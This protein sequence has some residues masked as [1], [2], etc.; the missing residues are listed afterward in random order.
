MTHI[1]EKRNKQKLPE[2]DQT[3]EFPSPPPHAHSMHVFPGQGSNLHHS[4][5]PSHS[6]DYTES[7]NHQATRELP[8][9]G[10]SKTKALN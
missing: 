9:N 2:E 3:M 4:R 10:I 8:D 6:S 5:D 1:K 7:F